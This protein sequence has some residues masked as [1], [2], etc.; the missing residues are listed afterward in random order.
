MSLM[1]PHRPPCLHLS[2]PQPHTCSVGPTDLVHLIGPGGHSAGAVVA[3]A[4]LAALV[5]GTTQRRLPLG[6]IRLIPPR[7]ELP[8][9]CCPCLWGQWRQGDWGR[10]IGVIRVGTVESV[11]R[12]YWHCIIGLWL[13]GVGSLWLDWGNWVGVIGLGSLGCCYWS[14]VIGLGSS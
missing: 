7:K 8:C 4:E 6:R 2:P 13:M 9:L 10:V 14:G 12:D 5:E 1:G 3:Q 11:G